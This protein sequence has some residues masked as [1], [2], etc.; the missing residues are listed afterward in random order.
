MIESYKGRTVTV[1]MRV[2]AYR[3]LHRAC[4][5]LKALDG[6]DKGRVVGHADHVTLWGCGLVVNEAGRQ[7]VLREQK[8]NVHAGVVGL[9]TN[10]VN[11]LPHDAPARKV[12]YNPY[13]AGTFT[14]NDVPVTVADYVRMAD[15]GKAY[16]LGTVN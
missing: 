6:A 11:L 9:V 16:A 7:R 15:D 14:V 2:F 8:K 10:G 13:R 5:S 4:W 12:S 3:N 1:G